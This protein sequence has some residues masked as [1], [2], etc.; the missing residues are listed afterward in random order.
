[1]SI[2]HKRSAAPRPF[3]IARDETAPPG[4]RRATIAIG[5]FDGIHIGHRKL[6]ERAIAVAAEAGGPSA[7][8]TFEPHPRKFF[9][10]DRPMFRLTPEPVKLAILKKLGLDG[11]FVR[12]F[13]LVPRGSWSATTS[14][15]GAAGKGRRRSWPSYAGTRD[16]CAR[17]CPR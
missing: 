13:D 7:V 10:P 8:L 5:N 2:T 9:A 1:M 4:L 11:V 14:I 3:V 17:S 12:R 16:F 15:S 6:I